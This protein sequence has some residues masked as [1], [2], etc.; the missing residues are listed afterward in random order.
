MAAAPATF[1][2]VHGAWHGAWAWDNVVPRLQA[3]GHRAIAVD[4]PGNG[5]DDTPPDAVDLAAYVAKLMAVID[6]VAGP[7]VLVGHSMGGITVSQS[8]ELRPDRIALSIYLCAFMLPDGMAVLEFYDT[9]LEPWM[10]GAHALLTHDPEGQ[11]SMINPEAAIEVFYQQ[12]DRAQA[13]A[14]AAR[15]TPQPQGV[16]HGKLHLTQGNYGSVPR[17]YIETLQDRS[18][19]LPLQRKMQEITGCDAV[20]GLDSDHA[21]QLSNPDGLVA[22]LLEVA[23]THARLPVSAMPAGTD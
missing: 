4:L 20:Y 3:G 17:V 2:L 14:A 8:A 16:R 13:E 19:H 5:H 11:T 22:M 18:V 15:L 9:Y 12:A 1:I 23:A 21:P 7:V 6:G 10:R